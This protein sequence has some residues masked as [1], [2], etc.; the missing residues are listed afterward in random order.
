MDQQEAITHFQEQFSGPFPFNAN[1]IVVALPDASFEEEM[2]TKIVFVG[3]TIGGAQGTNVEHVRAREHAPVVGRQRRRGRAQADVVQGGPGDDRRV[4][5]D[6]AKDAANAVGGQG[7]AAG[8]AAFE[9][10]LVSPLRHQLQHDLGD[11]LERRAVEPDLG[12]D[13]RHRNN[14]YMRPGT[15]YLA[16]RAILGKDNY[17]AALHYIQTAYRGGS[18]TEENLKKEFQ[19]YL[20]NQSPGLP[21]QARR[22]LHAVVGH[23]VH[24]LAGGRQPPDD[25][26]ARPGRTGRVLRRDRRLR[27]VRR[28]TCPATRAGRCRRRC[29]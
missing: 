1:G 24:G 26:R 21:Q 29:R 20:P 23:V 10:S 6:R 28:P 15:A 4:L 3:G 18:M 16:L 8:D 11:V 14:A 13:E 19:K 9:A 27:P 7:T 22:V 17:N 5:Q 25:H 12:H 2:Q